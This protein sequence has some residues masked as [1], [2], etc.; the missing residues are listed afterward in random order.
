MRVGAAL[1]VFLSIKKPVLVQGSW[2]TLLKNL[3]WVH[4]DS[5]CPTLCYVM[6][7]GTVVEDGHPNTFA[8]KI[9]MYVNVYMLLPLQP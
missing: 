1:K 6:V 2:V 5:G 8:Q 7:G 9:S 3:W 4:L